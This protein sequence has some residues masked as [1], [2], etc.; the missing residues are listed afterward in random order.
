MTEIETKKQSRAAHRGIA[1]RYYSEVEDLLDQNPSSISEQDL[2]KL[3]RA[4][5]RLKTKLIQLQ[6]LDEKYQSLLGLEALDNDIIESTEL[7]DKIGDNA[8]N[9]Y[10]F[11]QKVKQCR[12]STSQHSSSIPN[13]DT[14][15]LKLP[16]ISLPTFSGNYTDWMSFI[17][18][19]QGSVDSN[20][21]LSNSQKLHYLKASLRGDAAKLL[22]S[23]TISDS[24]YEVAKEILK[25][26]YSNPRLISRAHVKS[27]VDISNQETENSK[28]LNA[29]IESVE[30]H[31][32]ALSNLGHN[33]DEQDLFLLYIVVEKLSPITRQEWEIA[34]PGTDP[35]TFDQLK[36][37]LQNRCRALE[38]SESVSKSH[39]DKRDVQKATKHDATV[40]PRTQV[41]TTSEDTF[42]ECCGEKH[43]I[44]TCSKFK[45]LSSF[46]KTAMIKRHALCFNCLK[47]GHMLNACKSSGCRHCGKKHHSLL[48]RFPEVKTNATQAAEKVNIA[49]N[50][51][52]SQALLP[53]AVVE[54]VGNGINISCRALLD[55]GAQANLITEACARKLNLKQEHLNVQVSGI[56]GNVN[57]SNPSRVHFVVR[58]G[59][60]SVNM[61]ALVLPKL[62]G[63]LPN[64]TIF[65]DES[66]KRFE[67]WNMADPEFH[68]AG[69]I[70]IVFGA[71]VV[72]QFMLE[73]RVK[74][75]KR[76]HLRESKFGWVVIG[77]INS[78]ETPSNTLQVFHVGGQH[79]DLEQFWQ[80][81]NVPQHY[82]K[83][84]EERLCETHFTQ[85]TRRD[86]NGRFIVK[87]PFKVNSSKL[88]DSFSNAEKRFLSLE[89]KLDKDKSL[90]ARYSAF[91]NE[92]LELGHMEEVPRN[93]IE[94]SPE[95]SF[96]LP[97]HCV[98]KD[99][100]TTTKLRVV[101]DASVK[102][103]TGTSLNELL[104]VGP[105]IQNDLFA[106][107]LRFRF[108]PI[109]FSADIAKM[110]RQV[111]LDKEDKDFHRILW[112]ENSD[113]PIKHLRMTRVTYG[114]VPSSYHAI[115]ALF[116]LAED[117]G[118]SVICEIIKNDMYVDDLLSGCFSLNEAF[119]IQ[120]DLI[121][122]LKTGG[123]DLRKWTSNKQELIKNLDKN[124]RESVDDTVFESSDYIVKTLGASWSPKKDA[125]DFKVKIANKIPVTK[126]TILSEITTL[127][128]PLGWFSPVTITL[129]V[130]MQSLWKL[131]VTW[132]TT[133][134]SEIVQNYQTIRS[135]LKFL[136]NFSID[137]QVTQENF[138]DD[139]TFHV[140]CDASE[141]AYAACIYLRTVTEKGIKVK[142][143]VG[144]T[145]V[146]PLKS[147]SIPRLE[148]CAAL[149]GA[150]LVEAV[151][152]ALSDPRFPELKFFA[153]S[154]STIVLSWLAQSP[155]KWKTFV[156]NRVSKIQDILP[157][158]CWNHIST[159]ENPADCASRGI[160]G[161][162]I[163][164]KTLWWNGPSW[165]SQH[166]N[167]WPQVEFLCLR[168]CPEENKKIQ[169]I[170]TNVDSEQT[171]L[172]ITRYSNF[173][174]L[175]RVVAWVMKFVQILRTETTEK[176][177]S[178][179]NLVEAEKLILTIEQKRWFKEEICL[180]SQNL[181]L[182]PKHYLLPLTPFWD[183]NLKLLRVG[184]R[185][186][187][188]TLPELKKFPI[189]VPRNSPLVPLLIRFYHEKTL[190]GGCQ[191]TLFTI[192]QKFW[193]VR[194]KSKIK[195]VIKDCVTC[196]RFNSKISPPIM[197]DLPSERITESQPFAITG[198]DFTGSL[199]VKMPQLCKIYIVIFVC[200]TTKAIHLDVVFSL[201]KESCL[202]VIK[203]F[204]AR[205][206]VPSQLYSDNATTFISARKEIME[207]QN[208]VSQLGTDWFMIPAR[209]PHFGGLWE[210][211]IKSVKH[212]LR[213]TMK[214]HILHLEN[215]L[216]LLAQIESVLNSRPL[217]PSSDDPNDLT[218]LTPA[219]FLVGKPFAVPPL[220]SPKQSKPR[221]VT[222]KDL[223][224]MET[225][226]Q[227]FWSIWKHDYLTSLQPRSKW[228]KTGDSFKPNDMVFVADENTVPLQWPLG[229]VTKV[230]T[231][232]DNVSRVAE[233]RTQKWIG[234][235]PVVKLRKLPSQLPL[236][237]N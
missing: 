6:D 93:E 57:F 164:N 218:V 99:S 161:S 210:A 120:K 77:S 54:I 136:E 66:W 187:Q 168:N 160:T 39:K 129:K 113:E 38:A 103:S 236:N 42:C 219:H 154:D 169:I 55:T 97:H 119:K 156:R 142:L 94:I 115:R 40:Q 211:G 1:T 146:A 75:D 205:R 104:M 21:K 163:E 89:K 230:F 10:R 22:S 234:N 150:T 183:E 139:F 152:E 145:R 28:S 172:E 108:Y 78:S 203:R 135:S 96:Y 65:R 199:E 29:L 100:S 34:T 196:S 200:F 25:N 56:G 225:M 178:S 157:S 50:S 98:L 132:D 73:R 46:D 52:N 138:T 116:V 33:V 221:K 229:R 47:T 43:K 162:E 124:Y 224:Q 82:N 24:N 206:G 166:E 118:D 227:K 3:E 79:L 153:W 88:G 19:F 159:R 175:I 208:E 190:H 5:T 63:F 74:L 32:L 170:T 192:R 182:H 61:N 184:G 20:S 45:G 13:T 91:I 70:D 130:F 14:T 149:L 151:K 222:L 101:F 48:H 64:Q 186:S 202:N 148:L 155:D 131:D 110:Y 72:E 231:G 105:K 41:Y 193:I 237:D 114:L 144:K 197:G 213:R 217:V 209:A 121:A 180:L 30:E 185:I 223:Q 59:H 60:E 92:F 71:E 15:G 117:V 189:L 179:S 215:F 12:E 191:L 8:D 147:L 11:I 36:T 198:I 27:I 90:K 4:E 127:F 37:F 126:R 84:S 194:L 76:L 165:L 167:E 18:L 107:L 69:P 128:D 125:F 177:L 228:Q 106:I 81:E 176:M 80:L 26:R 44:F 68:K 214:T 2:I 140:F 158:S 173:S 123:F 226:K 171:F 207:L 212:H 83:T 109:V 201:T 122:A 134:P 216:T 141:K 85:T 9:L 87:L 49:L 137:R 17:D 143:L 174:K 7:N 62:T 86:E 53:T 112:R 51:N 23:V 95:K 67:H 232:N 35:Q 181:P 235:R 111:L 133:L 195:Q 58:T 204:I 31:R 220:S 102:T 16:K 188:S 233:V